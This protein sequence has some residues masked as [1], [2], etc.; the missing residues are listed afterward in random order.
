MHEKKSVLSILELIVKVFRFLYYPICRT[1]ARFFVKDRPADAILRRLCMMAFWTVYGYWPNF[2]YPRRFAEKLWNRM[3]Y[4]RNPVLTLVSDKY[5]VRDY[6]AKKIGPEYLIP[7]LWSDDKPEEIPY[8]QLPNRFVIKTNHGCGYNILVSDKKQ[9][10]YHEIGSKLKKWLSV[11][12]AQ[13][14][15]LGIAWGY[16]NIKPVLIIEEF[17]GDNGKPPVDYKFYCFSGRAELITVHFDRYGEKKS[18]TLN[19]DFERLRFRPSFKQHSIEHQKPLNYGAMLRLAETLSEGFNFIRVDLYSLENRIYFGE[20]TPYPVGVS[21]FTSF[22]IRDLDKTLGE[23]W[24]A[25][26]DWV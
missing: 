8:D 23:K 6:I 1:Y 9:A 25:N 12:Y 10:D 11:N 19:R 4:A 24:G 17:I 21:L 22:D 26:P 5:L 16:K 15:Y 7:L 3:L 13:D 18:I 2:L 14:T 20:L